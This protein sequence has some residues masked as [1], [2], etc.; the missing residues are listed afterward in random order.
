VEKW[1]DEKKGRDKRG[2]QGNWEE[3]P[4]R[5]FTVRRKHATRCTAFVANAKRAVNGLI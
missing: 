3:T 4:K 5:V 1:R 2:L